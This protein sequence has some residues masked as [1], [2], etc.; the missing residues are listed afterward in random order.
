MKRGCVL[1][2]GDVSD[3][4]IIER[5][6]ERSGQTHA[7]VSR[8]AIEPLANEEE[9]SLSASERLRPFVAVADSGG[10]QLSHETGRRFREIL[11]ARRRLRRAE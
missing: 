7:E 10:R 1:D 11:E 2:T 4:A 6:A 9:D 5:L 3:R 8:D